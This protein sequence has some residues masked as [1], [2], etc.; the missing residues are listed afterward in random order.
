MKQSKKRRVTLQQVAEHAGVSTSTA[1]LIVRNN[2][3]IS[4][5]TRQKVLQS[6][7]EL[8]YVYD[9]VAANLRSQSSTT[10]GLII[11][12]ISNTFFSE[13]LIGVHD[14]LEEVGYT[15]LL[16]T[17]FDS[18][19]KQDHLISTML[20]HR[21]GGLILCPVS[22]TT[23]ETALRLEQ[24]D[25]PVVLA[26][27]EIPEIKCDYVGADYREGALSAVNHLIQKGHKRIAFLGGIRESSTWVKR[28][29]GYQTALLEAGIE[30]DDSLVID[31]APTREGG[32]EALSKI[33]RLSKRPTA[34]FCFSDLIAF[35]VMQG[36]RQAGLIP[37]EDVDIVGFDNVPE[38]EISHPPLTTVSSFPR[39]SGTEAANL[40]HHK[41]SN[42]NHKQ[43]RIILKPELII[44]ESS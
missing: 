25:I 34:I 37:G 17:T 43:Q 9:R 22:G 39:R 31:S 36:V 40:L 42:T 6:M 11:T 8:G 33:L 16:G 41:M 2:P 21:V 30:V 5:A 32:L 3:R 14:A 10:V 1:S 7:R 13:F 44:R 26:V 4:E 29:E 19:D 20:E 38:A 12:D 18:I 15:V 24:L 35:G 28:M 23:Q 27:R